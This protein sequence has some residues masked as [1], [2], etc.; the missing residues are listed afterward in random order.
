M[1]CCYFPGWE[2]YI[3]SQFVGRI[4]NGDLR[5]NNIKMLLSMDE[6]FA[7]VQIV[8]CQLTD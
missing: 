3:I 2:N 1:L 6:M 4:R 7:A 5:K 8:V